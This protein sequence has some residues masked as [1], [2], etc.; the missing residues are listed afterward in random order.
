MS[1]D[2]LIKAVRPDTKWYVVLRP[3]DGDH[4]F[5]RGEVVDTTGWVHL[6]SLVENRY[7]SPLPHGASVPDE[8]GDGRRVIELTKTQERKVA[9][10]KR[11]PVPS[12]KPEATT[13]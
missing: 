10:K 4:R 3:F 11:P 5:V 1:E 6:D 8:D 13:E 12:R 9:S 2:A 7:I